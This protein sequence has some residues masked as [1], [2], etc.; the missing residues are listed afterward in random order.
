MKKVNNKSQLKNKVRQN[1][2]KKRVRFARIKKECINKRLKTLRNKRILKR[3]NLK[4]GNSNLKDAYNKI[5][6]TVPVVG[7]NDMYE[8]KTGRGTYYGYL[9]KPSLP[10]PVASNDYFKRNIKGGGVIPRDLVDLGRKTVYSM[11]KLYGDIT[12]QHIDSSPNVME[13][14]IGEKKNVMILNSSS[15]DLENIRKNTDI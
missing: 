10:D 12:T 3:C 2:T 9:T 5:N 14:P 8:P 7:K 4:G 15:I 11:Q 13:Q 1:S 6:D